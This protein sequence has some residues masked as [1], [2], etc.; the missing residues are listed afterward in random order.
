MDRMKKLLMMDSRTFNRLTTPKDKVLT[1]IEGEMSS[2]SNDESIPDDVKAK[3]FSSTQS[4][5]LKLKH[6]QW[7][8]T[9]DPPNAVPDNPPRRIVERAKP[10]SNIF[11][12][13]KPRPHQR[14]KRV[15]YR[16]R[17]HRGIGRN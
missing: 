17:R 2:I 1:S 12:S 5:F 16:Q 11:E 7:G 14:Q 3:L 9:P 8:E 4:R 15:S 10:V 13:N 6:P